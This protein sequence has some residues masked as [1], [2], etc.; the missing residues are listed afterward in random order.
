VI[1]GD[2]PVQYDGGMVIPAPDGGSRVCFVA[3]CQTHTYACGDCRDNDGDGRIDSDDP[4]CLG[5]CDNSEDSFHPKIPGGNNAPC[6]QDCYFDQ[7]TGSG[8]DQCYWDHRC[9]SHEVA[10]AYDP[11][12]M[13][14]KL[15]PTIKI[16]GGLVSCM[17]ARM[18][19]ST[20]CKSFCGPL[21][22]NGCDCFGCCS[23]PQLPPNVNVWLG[24]RDDSGN[25]TCTFEAVKKR[26]L[27]A[28]RPCDKV[29]ACDKPCGRCQLCIGKDTIPADCY[30]SGGDMGGVDGGGG[31]PG[32]CPMGVQPCGLPGQ[33]PCPAGW[34]CITGCCVPPLQ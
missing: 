31:V 21:T 7:D 27:K 2:G 23:F 28:C 33:M 1:F 22:P 34:Y 12:G 5:P 26:D 30:M 10:P 20:Q 14:C 4:D 13:Q 3:Q 19:Q 6:K 16:G 18:V 29:A 9:D 25:P 15:D 32:Q 8:N 17:T 24:S 11:E